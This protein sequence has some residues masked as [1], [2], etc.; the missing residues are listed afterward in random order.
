[1]REGLMTTPPSPRQDEEAYWASSREFVRLLIAELN[2]TLKAER[3]SAKK[4]Q[5][6]C[7]TFVFA[8][9]NFLDQQWFKPGGQTKYPI[10]SFS[11]AFFDIDA[12]LD[13]SQI[14]FPNKAVELHAM[15]HDEIAWFF[16]EAKEDR[17]AVVTGDLG[18]ETVDRQIEESDADVIIRQPCTSCRGTGE[19]FCIRKG[20]GDSS[21]CPRCQGTGDCK[22][23]S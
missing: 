21:S 18:S 5:Q 1:M 17:S 9:C 15:V 13:I 10:L 8:H 3:I 23:C 7:T 16:N 20:N 14:N 19:C 12:T 22:H 2:G 11:D 6:I 4:R